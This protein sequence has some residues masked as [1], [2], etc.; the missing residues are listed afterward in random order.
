MIQNDKDAKRRYE[1]DA[2]SQFQPE[3]PH[4]PGVAVAV[5]MAAVAGVV[6]CVGILWGMI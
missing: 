2:F 6:I 5:I 3:E 4:Y 1:L